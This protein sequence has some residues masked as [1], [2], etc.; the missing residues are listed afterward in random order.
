MYCTKGW[1]RMDDKTVY[2]TLLTGNTHIWNS[3]MGNNFE[4]NLTLRLI[5]ERWNPNWKA[6]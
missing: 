5:I 4:K 3:I 2:V 6:Y 1:P